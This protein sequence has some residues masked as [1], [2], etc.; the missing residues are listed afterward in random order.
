MAG[1]FC[2]FWLANKSLARLAALRKQFFIGLRCGSSFVFF[3]EDVFLDAPGLFGH[4]LCGLSIRKASHAT[5]SN[6]SRGFPSA[7]EHRRDNN[8]KAIE[9]YCY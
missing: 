3:W 8:V 4:P 9:I 5:F 6:H 1:D 7:K 2:C